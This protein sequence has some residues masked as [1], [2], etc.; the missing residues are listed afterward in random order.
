MMLEN[1][2]DLFRKAFEALVR[3]YPAQEQNRAIYERDALSAKV[4]VVK[5]P[6]A[7]KGH[8]CTYQPGDFVLLWPADEP[9]KKGLA[10]LKYKIWH[11]RNPIKSL[12]G[13]DFVEEAPACKACGCITVI[14]RFGLCEG[15]SDGHLVMTIEWPLPDR[16]TQLPQPLRY[17]FTRLF[18][19]YRQRR[20]T[21][22]KT[23]AAFYEQWVA[24][25]GGRYNSL[26]AFEMHVREDLRD[27]G[28]EW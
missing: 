24:E 8:L 19:A 7:S 13:P 21:R 26:R 18:R 6:I 23:V 9:P 4:G 3:Q 16:V 10:P 5:R 1:L 2:V 17:G 20:H 22:A 14:G 11:P 27:A 28:V 12:V 15:C 25:N